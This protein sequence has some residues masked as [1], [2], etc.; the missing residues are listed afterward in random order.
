MCEKL[1]KAL[2]S[3]QKLDRE[4]SDIP[5]Q[6][7][8]L[9]TLLQ[10]KERLKSELPDLEEIYPRYDELFL[11]TIRENPWSEK[12]FAGLEGDTDEI[13][14]QKIYKVLKDVILE[15]Y[16]KP[17][18]HFS[19]GLINK[20][21]KSL[22]YDSMSNQEIQDLCNQI[23]HKLALSGIKGLS[24]NYHEWIRSTLGTLFL[25]THLGDKTLKIPP[26]PSRSQE[27][28]GCFFEKG[29]I[30]VNTVRD[31]AFYG[32]TGGRADIILAKGELGRALAGGDI[33]VGRVVPDYTLKNFGLGCEMTGGTIHAQEVLC[34]VGKGMSG[35]TI[36]IEKFIEGSVSTEMSRQAT[37]ILGETHNA[38]DIG[39]GSHSVLLMD[40]EKLPDAGLSGYYYFDKSRDIFRSRRGSLMAKFPV[41]TEKDLPFHLAIEEGLWVFDRPADYQ[42]VIIRGGIVVYKDLTG[43]ELIGE[44]LLNGAII[45]DDENIS[46]E[47]AKARL[48][49]KRLGGMI[50]YL[51][52][53]WGKTW[54]GRKVKSVKL[55][56]L[57]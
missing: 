19:P 3:C 45:I 35:G 48:Y 29:H 6:A 52:K 31:G 23:Q 1:T 38:G 34:I 5:K 33:F 54:R 26:I 10:Y 14:N 47:E 41:L 7:D 24:S 12:V 30:T 11:Q 42:K 57:A 16:E 18:G 43:V 40:D 27:K 56:R 17:A 49:E 20:F 55:I 25:E 8:H 50:F 37:L 13:S 9:S 2:Q 22:M 39:N 46:L 44:F 36:Y 32:M 15:H 53:E 51:E 28:F 21:L 4:F